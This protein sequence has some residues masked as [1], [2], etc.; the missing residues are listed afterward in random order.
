MRSRFAFFV[1]NEGQPSYYLLAS[2][3][4]ETYS[5]QWHVYGKTVKPS[6]TGISRSCFPITH[7]PPIMNMIS[8]WMAEWRVY[9]FSPFSF[10]LLILLSFPHYFHCYFLIV[11]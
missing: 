4:G 3:I 7:M 10:T 8:G 2:T 1:F 11:E 9:I 6:E 5:T